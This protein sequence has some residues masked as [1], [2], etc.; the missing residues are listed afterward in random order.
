[1]GERGRARLSVMG[2]ELRSPCT[3]AFGSRL[4]KANNLGIRECST[5]RPSLLDRSAKQGA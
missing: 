5:Q 3:A 2:A 1:M 4:F